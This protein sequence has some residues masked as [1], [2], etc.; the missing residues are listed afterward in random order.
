[1]MRHGPLGRPLFRLSISA[2]SWGDEVNPSLLASAV[3]GMRPD[4]SRSAMMAAAIGSVAHWP[5]TAMG[6]ASFGLDFGGFGGLY[7][8]MMV[9]S[10]AG[11]ACWRA[12]PESFALPGQAADLSV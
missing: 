2:I 8:L 12:G 11:S 7:W 9:D 6:K 4:F 5:S 1:M 3:A 10:G